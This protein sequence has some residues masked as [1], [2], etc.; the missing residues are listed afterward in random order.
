MTRHAKSLLEVV[1]SPVHI[2]TTL[3]VRGRNKFGWPL[4][5]HTLLR[6]PRPAVIKK[7]RIHPTDASILLCAFK[8][9]LAMDVQIVDIREHDAKIDISDMFSTSRPHV[10]MDTF[11]SFMGICQTSPYPLKLIRTRN[12]NDNVYALSK[13]YAM[14]AI[15]PK[16]D[17]AERLGKRSQN[18][19]WM[20]HSIGFLEIAMATAFQMGYRDLR[21]NQ[22]FLDSCD[23]TETHDLGKTR[24]FLCQAV[25]MESIA[26]LVYSTHVDHLLW[27]GVYNEAHFVK[28]LRTCNRMAAQCTQDFFLMADEFRLW[29]SL[30][31]RVACIKILRLEGKHRQLNPALKQELTRVLGVDKWLTHEGNIHQYEKMVTIFN[32]CKTRI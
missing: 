27:G 13:L 32:D 2:V 25:G 15:L 22:D 7:S 14:L 21:M 17:I 30:C 20:L 4:L 11:V 5:G 28:V 19:Y 16:Q 23:F 3:A 24:M 29:Q 18:T 10:H 31:A 12:G 6:H 26:A 8:E 9:Q 1:L